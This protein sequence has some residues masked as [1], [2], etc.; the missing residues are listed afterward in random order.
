MNNPNR[1]E[2]LPVTQ[3]PKD[4]DPGQQHR[5]WW[6]ELRNDLVERFGP[7]SGQ[8]LFERWG[9]AFPMG[10]VL[11][12]PVSFALNDIA[13]LE[14]S[15][16]ATK[17]VG[18]LYRGDDEPGVIRFRAGWPEVAPLLEDILPIFRSLGLDLAD[19]RSYNLSV[20]SERRARVDDFGLRHAAGDFDARTAG[21][22]GDAIDAMWRGYAQKDG[23]NKLV[24]AAGI[25]WDE[26]ALI[27]A[28]YRYV[29][30]AGLGFS[31]EYVEQVLTGWPDFS[32]RVL[33]L[34][35]ARF[36]P[37]TRAEMTVA[38]LED[39][40][41]AEFD[42][43]TRLD[44]DRTL[45]SLDAFFESVVRTNVFMDR[46]P[47]DPFSFKI[48][49]S[50]N[51]F[52][53]FP[54]AEVETFVYSPRVEGLHLRAARVAR[55][56][57]RWSDRPE[58]FRTEVL[59]LMKAQDVKNALI[60]PGGAKGAF[61]VKRSLDGLDRAQVDDEV[62]QCYSAFINGML[63]VVDN[64][65]D[66]AVQTPPNV[67]RRDGPDHYLVVAADKGTATMSD[68]ANSIA[69][70]RGFWLGDAFASGGS[71][72]Y[73]HKKMGITARG[74]WVSLV[75][76]LEDLG[77]DPANEEF[78]VVGIGDMSG[79]VFGN[80]MLLSRH[81]RLVGAFDHRHIF[82]DPNPDPATSYAERQRLANL[83]G[84][85]WDDYSRECI[86]RGGGVYSRGAK[87]IRLSPE[88]RE[89][90]G[91]TD[92]ELAPPSLVGALL[93]ARVDVLW[94]GGIGT[95]VKERAETHS[96][97]A[98]PVNDAIRVDAN[99]LRCRV[100]VEGGNLGLTQRARVQYASGGGRINTDFIDNSAGVDTSDR[101][102]NLKILLDQAVAERVISR[103]ERNDLISEVSDDIASAVLDDSLQQTRMLGVLEFDAARFLDQ[104]AR[105]VDVFEDTEGLDR[106]GWAQ[107]TVSEIADRRQSGRGFT[108]PEIAV[109][110]AFAKNTLTRKLLD[111][112]VLD[113]PYHVINLVN[114]LPE[115][116]RERFGDR[117]Q[118]HPLR[119]EIL[120]TTLSNNIAHRVGTGF[121]Y[122]MTEVTGLGT[123]EIAQ[124]YIAVRDIF[125]LDG[126]WGSIDSVDAQCPPS[127]RYEMFREVQRF[128]SHTTRWFLRNR[129]QPLDIAAEVQVFHPLI[130]RAE[131][132]LA[133]TRI[134]HDPRPSIQG[135]P[136][137]VGD[138]VA[139]LGP[140][141]SFLDVAELAGDQHNLETVWNVY[142][143]L[144]SA[145]SLEW[146][147]GQIIDLSSDSHWARLAKISLQD[148]L[149]IQRRRITKAVLRDTL[150]HQEPQ[151]RVSEWLT[152]CGAP[153]QHATGTLGVLRNADQ[154]D[155]PMLT[156]ATQVL[157]NLAT[158]AGRPGRYDG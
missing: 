142:S 38:E 92:T 98:D 158:G 4:H 156:V 86:S 127:A 133:A 46:K 1:D 65:V 154:L 6:A 69:E 145:L 99:E 105:A 42:R 88:V 103:E 82:V 80:G 8:L 2:M 23:F 60:V 9:K 28:A 101:E 50:R 150:A 22:V 72:G 104:H 68:L 35:R 136:K 43:V 17:T 48:D 66:G 115:A 140:L 81:I 83:N 37:A 148:D 24:I 20:G 73:D 89:L 108:R 14:G 138:Q 36:D 118:R 75:R 97:A 149:F 109:L 32:R 67:V 124:A 153:V 119:R 56:G 18:M 90:L 128:A 91:I 144:G 100:I 26:A 13:Q 11:E 78:T 57:L 111:S 3:E 132:V 143:V 41:T 5:R 126:L 19:H 107:P 21:L 79:D 139:A 53:P 116:L 114:Y 62:R 130:E 125:D 95:F 58:D 49:A 77:I 155:V 137:A 27:R 52:L 25:T 74:A 120:A 122:R 113:D 59:G 131:D 7:D 135:V 64:L 44:E 129:R 29:R 117:V 147:Q 30:Q 157:H 152:R 10:Y 93:R 15:V 96:D 33:Q 94:N 123:P 71:T 55:G 51:P 70:E 85:S 34:F 45:R 87:S 84:T 151:V 47:K 146:L 121:F 76:H 112:T 106:A 110:L 39:A 16:G 61:V 31:Q 102:V 54:R 141:A 63:D 134:E 40:R 12:V